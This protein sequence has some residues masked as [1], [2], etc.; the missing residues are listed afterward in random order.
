[1]IIESDGIRLRLLK[2][3]DFEAL[4]A[5]YTPKIFEHML[6]QVE[7]FE[8]MVAWLEA[9]MNQSNV[10]I[11]A[12][13]NP[14]TAEVIGTTRI[15]AIDETNKSCEMGATF[16]ALS[17]QRTHVNTSVKRALLSYCFEERGMIRVQFKTDAE[18]VRSQKAIER[19][20]AVKEGVLRNERIRSNGKPRDAVVYSIIDKE[21]PKVKKDLAKKANKYT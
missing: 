3:E 12:V 6:N 18:N 20:G 2:R 17:A 15:Y 21:W 11:F 5:L 1:M 10:L 13:E 19:I 4:W 16:Y 7:I 8:D 14:E 9:G